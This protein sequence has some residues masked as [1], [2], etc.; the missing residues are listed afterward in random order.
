MLY[1]FIGFNMIPWEVQ[2]IWH[3][4][5]GFNWKWS[6]FRQHLHCEP[7][8]ESSR[9]GV[10]VTG[11]FNRKIFSSLTH[12]RKYRIDVCSQMKPIAYCELYGIGIHF[13]PSNFKHKPCCG[14][15][16]MNLSMVTVSARPIAYCGLYGFRYISDQTMWNTK[17]IVAAI[18]SIFR[19]LQHHWAPTVG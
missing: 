9:R 15:G 5:I 10:Q 17:P 12:S 13:N 11:L 4:T 14:S 18:K 7:I 6:I 8:S 1:N 2:L 19:W 16:D 3:D